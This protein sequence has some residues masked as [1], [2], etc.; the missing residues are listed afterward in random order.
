MP[1]SAALH[2]FTVGCIGGLVLAMMAR[3][4]LGHT[5]RADGA[6]GNAAGLRRADAGRRRA[7]HAGRQP[8]APGRGA[9]RRVLVP[10]VRAVRVSLRPHAVA[11][12]GDGRPG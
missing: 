9:G 1:G 12:V 7:G 11:P 6:A 10:R 2:A 5:G 8:A 4:G 3:V